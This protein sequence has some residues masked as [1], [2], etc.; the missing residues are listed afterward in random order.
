MRRLA[1]LTAGLACMLVLFLWPVRAH[2]LDTT[3]PIL[4]ATAACVLD[5]EGR[6]LYAHNADVEMAPASITK[7]MTA[8]VALDSGVPLD[9]PF[10]FTETEFNEAA[11]VAGYKA[12]DI[13]TFGELL[14]VTLIYSGNDAAMNVA[15]AVAGSKEAFADLMNQKC[16]ELGLEHTHFMN[17][18]GLEE[19]GHYS[20]AFDLC[21][22]GRY[23]MERYPFIRECVHTPSITITAGGQTVT[24]ETTDHLMGVYEGLRGI[25]TGNT[26]SGTSFLASARRNN[27]TL[28]ACALCCQTLEGR[29]TDSAIMLD[30]GFEQYPER[31]LATGTLARGTAPWQDGFWLS[32][33]VTLQRAV[34]AYPFVEGEVHS[35]TTLTN[36]GVRVA[37]NATFGNT[38]WTQDEHY[39]TG[40]SYRTGRPERSQA[41][42]PLVQHL[43]TQES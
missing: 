36:Q 21:V 29:F 1:R 35:A 18:H 37:G 27:V 3:P 40:V 43:F 34:T 9:E 14:R 22:L 31:A 25:K 32:C 33:P 11:Q 2:A 28:Y 20:T 26:E 15:Y 7:V 13:V 23:A 10:I 6:L 30:W 38:V 16:A 24:L 17:P 41:W 4:E 42:N 39:L 5:G 8:I 12:G 19:P